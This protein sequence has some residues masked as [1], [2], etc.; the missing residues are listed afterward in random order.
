MSIVT[1]HQDDFTKAVD[2]FKQDISGLKTGR[3]NPAMLDNL[4]VEAY[5]VLNPIN[6][7]ASVSV[8]EAR[9]IVIAPWDKSVMKDI[10]RAINESDININPVNDGERIRLVMPLMTEESRKEMVKLMNQKIEHARIAIRGVRDD[11]REQILQAEKDKEFG[12]DM[13]YQLIEEL[14]KMTGVQNDL[15]K[16]LGEEKEVEIMTI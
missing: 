9:T 15:L 5:G 2:H 11:I 3:A 16:K 6:Q 1:D 13:K 8:P 4:R 10:E 7:V 12:E 14:D